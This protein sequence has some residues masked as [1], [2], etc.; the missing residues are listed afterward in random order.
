[1]PNHPAPPLQVDATERELLTTWSK[2]QV[3]PQR[4]VMRAKI[5]LLAAAGTPNLEIA[6]RLGCSLPTVGKWRQRFQEAGMDGLGDQPGR[7]RLATYGPKLEDRVVSLTLSRPPRGETHWSTRSLAARLGI[8][9]VTVHRI[10]R[11]HRIQPHRSSTFKFSSDP[12]L[13]EKVTDVVGLYLDP[14]E[15][16]VVL[17]VDEKSQIQALDRTQ[18]LLPMRPGQV[19][20][21]THDYVR[22]GTTTL[23]AALEIATGQV[24]ATVKPRHRHQEFLAFL[25][26]LDRRI[27]E[28]LEIHVVLDNLS[29]HKTPE[30]ERWLRRHPRFHFHFVP[31]SS[32]WVNM[33]EGWLSQLENK[34]LDRGSFRS[35]PELKQ[36][37]LDFV[38]VTNGRAKPWVWT[39]DANE[40]IRK[41]RKLRDRLR[42]PIIDPLTGRIKAYPSATLH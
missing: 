17:S 18:P 26:T 41:V 27:P 4:Q 10:W 8:S 7:G 12:Q 29:A 34:A 1:M 30:V 20:R 16:A 21:R 42:A 9:H 28:G 3:L 2:S 11:D 32:S 23:F 31:T 33:V 22:H 15:K 13:V 6:R 36:A 40:I 39:M 5:C 24:T 37:I 14:P 19:E 25:R 35:V 38:A